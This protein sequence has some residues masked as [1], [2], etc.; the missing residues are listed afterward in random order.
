MA[1][2]LFE[3]IVVSETLRGKGVSVI[4]TMPIVKACNHVR[5]LYITT[6]FIDQPV[7]GVLVDNRA[8]LNV[9]SVS[10]L[11]KLVKKKSDILPTNL[12]TTNFYGMVA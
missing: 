6:Q 4:L 3:E 7:F 11:R 12:I 2:E 10:I 9:F 1:S 8:T 5:P